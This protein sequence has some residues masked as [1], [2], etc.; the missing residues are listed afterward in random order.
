MGYVSRKRPI[1]QWSKAE[2]YYNKAIDTKGTYECDARSYLTELYL[3]KGD[4]ET[5]V[6]KADELCS[7]C[8]KGVESD[9]YGNSV[10]QVRSTFDS[11]GVEWPTTGPCG[12]ETFATSAGLHLRRSILSS[13]FFAFILVLYNF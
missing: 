12:T 9:P 3:Q 7:A 4:Y 6:L 1:P 11:L 5:A 8:G 13:S 2:Y 10:R